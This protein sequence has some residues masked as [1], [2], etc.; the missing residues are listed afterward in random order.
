VTR[1]GGCGACVRGE[2]FI[3][4][5]VGK[6]VDLRPVIWYNTTNVK[7]EVP[8]LAFNRPGHELATLKEVTLTMSDSISLPPNKQEYY[9]YLIQGLFCHITKI[10]IS[11]DPQKR[12]KDLQPRSAD[13]LVL[14]ATLTCKDEAEARAI[15]SKLHSRYYLQHS[16]YEWFDL[17]ACEIVKDC[18][19]PF[20]WHH[21]HFTKDLEHP[22]HALSDNLPIRVITTTPPE[23][24]T[25]KKAWPLR[26]ATLS[27]VAL[28]IVF[29]IATTFEIQ[30]EYDL[31]PLSGVAAVNMFAFIV[32]WEVL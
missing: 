4:G 28:K 1:A 6:C 10:G 3:T 24:R 31:L 5:A 13:W 17:P 2:G 9:V 27:L 15:E 29:A 16:H 12:I 23:P 21:P 22:I 7:N 25:P 14:C 19:L 30:P 32:A 20:V 26:V 11:Y 8:A 18:G